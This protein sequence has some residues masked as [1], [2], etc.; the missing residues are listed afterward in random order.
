MVMGTSFSD[1]IELFI[2]EKGIFKCILWE[3]NGNGEHG[4][5]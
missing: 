3:K 2:Q 5:Y 4:K 1:F